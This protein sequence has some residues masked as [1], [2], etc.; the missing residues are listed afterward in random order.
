MKAEKTET[1]PLAPSF[2]PCGASSKRTG[3]PC[4]QPAMA[5][6]RC[7]LHGGKSTG[8]KTAEGKQRQRE[9]SLKTGRYTQDTLE[10][11]RR[12]RALLQHC[13]TLLDCLESD[14]L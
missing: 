2:Q 5:N 12:V 14:E 8:A 10:E 3:L 13:Q 1:L 11:R 4:Q 9:A 6:G 7:R